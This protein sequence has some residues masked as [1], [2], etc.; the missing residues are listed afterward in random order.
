MPFVVCFLSV[1]PR[2]NLSAVTLRYIA[3]YLLF[4]GEYHFYASC[5]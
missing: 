3:I 1:Q 5:T 4:E 2:G